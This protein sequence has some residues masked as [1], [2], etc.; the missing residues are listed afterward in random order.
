MDLVARVAPSRMLLLIGGALLA[1]LAGCWA[2]GA[3]GEPPTSRRYGESFGLVI[4]WFCI[5][6]FGACAFI[7]VRR[8][9][10]KGDQLRISGR[11]I[12]WKQWSETTI[13]WSEIA[14]VHVWQFKGQK[15]VILT[16]KN[17]HLFPSETLLGR[18]AAA[19][20][21]LTAGDIAISVA[22]LDKRFD[23]VLSAIDWFRT[24]ER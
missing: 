22:G 11:G 24:N 20:R 17:P 6:F 16:L 8:L 10:E 2:V 14:D 1:V 13:P 3:F 21:A 7:G 4:G 15:S 19:N 12:Y 5:L 18:L 23:D 9:T